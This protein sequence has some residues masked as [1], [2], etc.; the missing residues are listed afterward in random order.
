MI[1]LQLL[2]LAKKQFPLLNFNQQTDIIKAEKIL[3][4]EAKLNAAVKLNDVENL[5]SFLKVY[6]EKFLPLLSDK[7]I[8]II[9]KGQGDYI[10]V[11]PFNEETVS[12]EILEEFQQVFSANILAYL[13]QCIKKTSWN[14]LKTVFLHYH[15]L[16]SDSARE[17]I[18][19]T[20]HAKNQAVIS[21]LH[22]NQYRKFIETNSYATAVAYYSML[23]AIDSYDFDGDMMRLNN[24]IVEMQKSNRFIHLKSL[25]KILY[26][27]TFFDAYHDNL[28]E[29]LASNQDVAYSW[30]YPNSFSLNGKISWKSIVFIIITIIF[31]IAIIVI[32]PGGA[33]A[34]VALSI[35]VVR[36]ILALKKK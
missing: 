9:I 31:C 13:N 21:A 8:G 27:V 2:D 16:V 29:T 35:F 24:M 25:G 33:G 20:L 6:G 18:F 17:E 15:F 23:G 4:A 22:Q 7:N 32:V 11:I 14:S 1:Q 26:A 12:E 19:G 28:K 34:A 3:K 36:M 5:I 30:M 10:D